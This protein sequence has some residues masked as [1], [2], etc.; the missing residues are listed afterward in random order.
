MFLI[1]VY[2]ELL[3]TTF[4]CNFQIILFLIWLT[5]QGSLFLYMYWRPAILNIFSSCLAHEQLFKRSHRK[6]CLVSLLSGMLINLFHRSTMSPP[7]RSSHGS[8]P[9]PPQTA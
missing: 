5:E 4:V 9:M 2:A 7:C 1:L 6:I 3:L 8:Q